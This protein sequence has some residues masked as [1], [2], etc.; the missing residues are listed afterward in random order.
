MGKIPL[1]WFHFSLPPPF[2]GKILG[3]F[4]VFSS[5]RKLCKYSGIMRA[6]WSN[7][8]IPHRA[9]NILVYQMFSSL[10]LG[11]VKAFFRI[12]T[13]DNEAWNTS[14]LLWALC[15][16]GRSEGVRHF[17]RWLNFYIRDHTHA[18]WEQR[19]GYIIGFPPSSA[20]QGWIWRN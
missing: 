17:L 19:Q 9:K 15:L 1:F 3:S 18:S 20:F 7:A 5:L 12:W 14:K 4:H 16:R 6:F 8:L 2:S 10:F 11:L 13:L